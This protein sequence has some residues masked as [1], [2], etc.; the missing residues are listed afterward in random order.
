MASPTIHATAD[1]DAAARRS[2][3][4]SHQIS[5]NIH[6]SHRTCISFPKQLTLTNISRRG[7]NACS[8]LLEKLSLCILPSIHPSPSCVHWFLYLPVSSPNGNDLDRSPYAK[9]RHNQIS[10][11]DSRPT[12]ATTLQS[13]SKCFAISSMILHRFSGCANCALRPAAISLT[14]CSQL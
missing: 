13:C 3:T 9:R 11:P 6:Q 1:V 10:C 8:R 14:R 7:S 4:P 5:E 12:A 2:I